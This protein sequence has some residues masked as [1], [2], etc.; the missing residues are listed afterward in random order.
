MSDAFANYE[1]TKRTAPIPAGWMLTEPQNIA[2]QDLVDGLVQFW[3]PVDQC[4]RKLTVTVDAAGT[5]TPCEEFGTLFNGGAT[6]LVV[7]DPNYVAPPPPQSFGA[8]FATPFA[9][10][11]MPTFTQP[12][13]SPAPAV[14]APVVA[15]PIPAI[16]VPV[17]AP[18][19]PV[20][21]PAT[22]VPPPVVMATP[23]VAAPNN[24]LPF[25]PPVAAQVPASPLGVQAG[26]EG[27][28]GEGQVSAADPNE[29]AAWLAARDGV[30]A[31]M[32]ALK[33]VEGELRARIVKTCFPDGLREGSNKCSL[34]DG[35]K[36]TVTGVVN[37]S[38]DDA[39]VPAALEA[40]KTHMGVAPTGLFRTTYE[41]GTKVFKTLD[42]NTK[43]LL[44]N[45]ITEKQGAPQLKVTEAK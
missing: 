13:V 1:N 15:A 32:E 3:T 39:L 5:V 31:Q 29:V 25:Q 6:C 11:T 38:V 18:V 27:D 41:V 10:P 9:A 43:N 37:R 35:R 44:A 2:G 20:V 16:P 14:A 19:I 4:W 45:V 17:A 26:D 24:I 21:V 40:L 36:L 33:K 12:S 42:Q 28:E 22:P 7:K 34:P 23:V 30:L 8:Q